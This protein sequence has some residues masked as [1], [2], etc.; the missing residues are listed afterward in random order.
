MGVFDDALNNIKDAV[1]KVWPEYSKQLREGLSESG[2]SLVEEWDNEQVTP[3]QL[4]YNATHIPRTVDEAIKS[5]VDKYTPKVRVNDAGNGFIVTGTQDAL[6]SS[7]SNE[8]KSYLSDTFKYSDLKSENVAAALDEINNSLRDQI[9]SSTY[10]SIGGNY[11]YAKDYANAVETMNRQNPM[12]LEGD[13]DREKYGIW[14]YDKNGDRVKK[15]PKEWIDYWR[16][17]YSSEERAAL[18]E[19]SKQL[20]NGTADTSQEVALDYN[21]RTPYLVMSGGEGGDNPIYGFDMG[22]QL[23]STGLSFV[24]AV[25]ELGKGLGNAVTGLVYGPL[26]IPGTLRKNH[27]NDMAHDLGHADDVSENEVPYLTEKQ[28]NDK[29]NSLIGKNIDE[30][31]SEEQAFLATSLSDRLVGGGAREV[32][33]D[34]NGI[35]DDNMLNQGVNY[36]DY[37]NARD[38]LSSTTEYTEAAKSHYEKQAKV[39][40]NL[41]DEVDAAQIYNPVGVGVGT[42]AG[43]ILRTLAESG[44]I[45]TLTGGLVNMSN[46]GDDLAEGIIKLATAGSKKLGTAGGIAAALQAP[47]GKFLLSLTAEIPEDI[48]QTAVDN[49]IVGNGDENLSLLTPDNI[50]ENTFQNLVFRAVFGGGTKAL[51]Y[52]S[53]RNALKRLKAQAPQ[54]KTVDPDVLFDEYTT[55]KKARQEGN[56]ISFDEEGRA[57]IT[58]ADGNTKVLENVKASIFNNTGDPE[59]DA[60][61][62]SWRAT[63]PDERVKNVVADQP[64]PD[65]LAGETRVSDVAEVGDT[66]YRDPSIDYSSADIKIDFDSNKYPGWKIGE[67]VN[68]GGIYGEAS[69]RPKDIDYGDN[70]YTSQREFNAKEK[71][72]G[73]AVLEMTPQ[74]YITELSD[75]RGNISDSF[76]TDPNER[77]SIEYQK[78]MFSSDG[79]SVPYITYG[80]DGKFETQE[81]RH[82][83]VAAA[84]LGMGPM[85]VLIKYNLD[86]VPEIISSGRYTDITPEYDKAVFWDGVKNG[87]ISTPDIVNYEKGVIDF[88]NISGAKPSSSPTWSS[89]RIKKNYYKPGMSVSDTVRAGLADIP[90][91]PTQLNNWHANVLESATLAFDQTFIP[92]FTARYTTPEDQS[93]FVRNMDYLFHLQKAEKL[94][95]DDAIGKTYTSDG[96][97]YK[98]TAEDVKFYQN[99]V[100]PQMTALREASQAALGVDIPT[101]VGY[102]PHTDYSPEFMTSEEL[103]QQGVLYKEY[104]GA[105]AMDD[106]NF[107]TAKLSDDISQRYRVFANNMLWDA[108]GERL[109]AA[110][111]MEEFHA[112]GVEATAEQA[113]AIV[114]SKKAQADALKKSDGAKA[115]KKGLDSKKPNVDYDEINEKIKNSSDG[116]AQRI[117]DGYGGVYGQAKGTYAEPKIWAERTRTIS[118]S[119]WMRGLQTPDG[120]LY[121][122][123]G[124]MVVAGDADAGFLAKRIFEENLTG[125][126]VR[127][128][129]VEY[130]AQDGRRTTKGAEYIADKWINRLLAK[131]NNQPI[132]RASLAANLQQMIYYEGISRV[133]RWI[134]RADLSNFSKKNIG[135]LDSF[136][137]RQG[138][139]SRQLSDSGIMGKINSATNAIIGAR[140]KSLFWFNFKN[141]I[142]QTSECIRLFTEFNIRDDALVTIKRLATDADFRREVDEWVNLIVPE[143]YSDAIG[144]G[145]RAKMLEGTAEA[146]SQIANKSSYRNGTL[147]VDKLTPSDIKALGKSFD[148]FASSP[149][150][151][152]ENMKNRVIMA[153]ILQEAQRKGLSGNELFNYVNKRFE[154]IG[155]AA[156]DMGKLTAADNPF[157]RIATNLKSFGIREANMY[158]NNIKDLNEGSGVG[159]AI[160]YII[161]NIGWKGGLLLV[162]SK[163]GYGAMSVFGLDPFGLMDD[164]YTGVD[165]EDYNFLDRVVTNPAV[166]ALLSGGFTSF[167][168]QLYWASRQAYEGQI[169]ATEEY[170][171]ALDQNRGIF[172][173]S[174]IPFDDIRKIGMGFIPGYTQ[175]QRV[176]SMTDLLN[177][178]W[179]IGGSGNKKYEAPD[180][181]FDVAAGYMFGQSNTPNARAYNQTPDYL[182]GLID[183]G[184]PGLMQQW[185]REWGG[186][187]QFDPVDQTNYSDWFNGSKADEA[188]WRAGYIHFKNRMQEILGEYSDKEKKA[189]SDSEVESLKTSL[190]QQIATLQDQLRSFTDAYTAKHPEGID[191]EKM[192]N[193]IN[194]LN[195]YQSI[196][197]ETLDDR[198][199]RKLDEWSNAVSRY[200][201]AGLPAVTTYRG[202]EDGTEVVY[203][204]QVRAAVQ[205]RYGLPEEASRRIKELYD[206]KWKD[207]NEQYRDRYY[208]TKGSKNKKAIQ[209]EYINIV[210]QD[211]DPIV[212]LYGGEI[213][214]NDTVEDIVEDVFNSMIPKYGQTA[215]SYLK[216]VYKNYHGTIKYSETGNSTLTQINNLL[217]QGKTAQ[218]KALART[219]LQRVQENRT[220]LSRAELERLQKILND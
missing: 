201:Q 84:E 66:L 28:W 46:I 94:S 151:F 154:R 133:N 195:T 161:K 101:T 187:R 12:S 109:A 27:L 6:N 21:L 196:G 54:L 29:F 110:K 143:K 113:D 34:E 173:F 191:E 134:A 170:D 75:G 144:E 182:Q 124:R 42:A 200:S 216:D 38:N 163:L 77:K 177:R 126:Q 135:A 30:L 17:E 193:L 56:N 45:S 20:A 85:P 203:P 22:E 213:F 79:N 70:H 186:Y 76:A 4:Q 148:K 118:M 137:Y 116:Y 174:D 2:K 190:N 165:E 211:L 131:S 47:L 115:V 108:T 127:D 64:S 24:N 138:I 219:L 105:S 181:P 61:G 33:A 90:S 39:W 175:T 178:G 68:G 89:P 52:V 157:F 60:I 132:S 62:E 214:Q 114:A 145:G 8:L 212:N 136:V 158:L 172:E 159:A 205:G 171:R 169:S 156:N 96:I 80:A 58:D 88:N 53:T 86:N 119:D 23:F 164:Q 50:A 142:L 51:D 5:T 3:E 98:V 117:H 26:N 125:K 1:D 155:L 120:S 209:E 167:I 14:G 202:T 149:V 140:M 59:L 40:E 93:A 81:G 215:K 152:G 199:Q 35:I 43:V 162:M 123:G 198:N 31:T 218:A 153:G 141:G 204:A 25:N 16:Q 91:D 207:L 122:N 69:A 104:T 103:I 11:E 95:L 65:T 48:V 18:F 197:N 189:Y 73:Y 32:I 44:I 72:I 210:R 102:F 107:T 168:P 188:Q 7:L 192:N 10:Q 147:N 217:D 55:F 99:Y 185:N 106:G 71:G 220:S 15:L 146:M 176:I 41:A 13:S 36:E 121:N 111:V 128:L 100:E 37:N 206:D 129:F 92:E 194:V 87:T 166:N 179:A 82:R 74:Q 180:N 208:S 160:G 130:L 150:D 78:T 83:A 49:V 112:D 19:F 63:H 184:F 67:F 97:E 9:N 183:N 57:V 139:I